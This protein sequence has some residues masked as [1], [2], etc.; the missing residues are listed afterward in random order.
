LGGCPILETCEFP[1]DCKM[2]TYCLWTL[3]SDQYALDAGFFSS[4]KGDAYLHLHS[5]QKNRENIYGLSELTEL[6]W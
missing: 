5:D 1:L 4:L 6:I 3:A 2:W